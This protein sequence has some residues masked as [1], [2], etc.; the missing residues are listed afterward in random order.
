V[1]GL[2][3]IR[4]TIAPADAE[5]RYRSVRRAVGWVLIAFF[6]L[7]PFLSFR[8]LPLA[9]FDVPRRRLVL[10]GE[11]FTPHDTWALALLIL[12]AA[13]SL[14]LLTALLGRVWCGWACPQTVWL[15]WIYRP[16]DRWFEGTPNKRRRRDAGPN[17]RTWWRIKLT[18]HLAFLVVTGTATFVFMSWFVGGRE[19]LSGELKSTGWGVAAFLFA[20]FHADGVWFREQMCHYACPYAR[21]QG[22]LMDT[23]SLVVAY[24]RFR[25]EPRRKGKSPEGGDCIDCGR[26]AAVCPMGI[27]IR[28][29]DQLQCIHCLTCV[30]ACDAVMDKIEKPRGLIRWTTDRDA[31][32]RPGEHIPVFGKRARVYSVLLVA[33]LGLLFGGLLERDPVQVAVARVPDAEIFRELPDGRVTNRFTFH[34]TNRAREGHSFRVDSLDADVEVTVPGAP[35]AVDM[36]ED[37][38]VQ[39]F[40]TAPRASFDAGRLPV[41][42]VVERDDG[43]RSEGEL[44]MLGPGG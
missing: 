34:I 17:D 4:S 18:K 25:G 21:F 12:T 20:V 2:V 8:G 16:I 19:I 40:V 10:L 15:E 28:E 6:A 41:R 1:A 38:R 36:A 39:G 13:L 31:P 42:F 27:D 9:R 43:L 35:W 5:G 32:A 26:C 11:I 37:T 24:D 7:V 30:D 44:T 14:F 22:A 3:Q 29:G 23:N 33:V